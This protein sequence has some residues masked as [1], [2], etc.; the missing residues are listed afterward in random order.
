RDRLNLQAMQ[1]ASGFLVGRHDYERFSDKRAE[2]KSTI[3][4][5]EKA[6]IAPTGDLIIFRIAA[7]HFLWKM[8]RRVVGCIVEVGRGNLA[9]EDLEAF[10]A[11]AP[12]PAKLKQ[13]S[14]AEHTAPASGL[15]L[16]RVI[17]DEDEDVDSLHPAIPVHHKDSKT[18]NFN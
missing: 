6:E 11:S 14:I 17:Y 8:V 15:F 1:Q 12:L 16:E 10:V 18:Q 4:V 3:V 2:D 5:V 13:F 7:S 9:P